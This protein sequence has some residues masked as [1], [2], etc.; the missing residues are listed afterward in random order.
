MSRGLA[1][2]SVALLLLGCTPATRPKASRDSGGQALVDLALPPHFP[3]FRH[4][5]PTQAE[6]ELG[7]LLFHDFRLSVDD[8]RS[9]GICHEGKKGYTD[10]FAKAVGAL[11]DAHT[12]NTLSLLNLAWRGPL[13]W[14][15]P[16]LTDLT[17][18]MQVPLYGVHPVEMGTD[19]ASLPDR[20]AGIPQ[21]PPA[22]AA[23]FPDDPAPITMANIEAALV[24]YEL[25]T[26]AGDTPYDRHLQGDARALSADARAGM[27]LFHSERLGCGGCHGGLFFDLPTDATGEPTA[28]R[29]EYVNVGMYNTD[30]AGGLPVEETGL[31]ALT[32]DP[33]DM[34]R[35]RVP[36]LRGVAETGPWGHDGSFPSLGDIIDAYAR[37]GR[38]LVGG[39]YPGD[40]AQSP[41]KD[42]RI[43]GFD[44][45]ETEK[46]Q[47]I[48]FLEALTDEEAN[49]RPFLQTP[50]CP[51]D[52]DTG[53][54]GCL[55]VEG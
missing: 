48:A 10:G 7:R 33:A 26:I 21:Y 37:G 20:L 55:P 43:T 31:H 23:A 42:P 16:D 47:L 14:V 3:D 54:A 53:D 17:E 4:P 5:V 35:F 8:A 19:P 51:D 12:R 52:P 34:G 29:P 41:F 44:I 39:P 38:L 32:G 25:L 15:R 13:G 11:G 6:A 18:Q 50:W 28:D 22:F 30:G 45:T 2:A 1:G 9:C 24:A 27:D 36:S 49:A 40:G 46:R